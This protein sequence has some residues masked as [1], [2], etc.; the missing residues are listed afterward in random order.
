MIVGQTFHFDASHKLPTHQG[1]CSNLH[2]HTYRLEVEVEGEVGDDGMVMDFSELKKTVKEEVI[3]VL[4]H[5]NL[6]DVVP[7]PTAENLIKWIEDELKHKMHL[8][9]IKI[10]EGD[11]KWAKK[12][13]A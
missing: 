9:S 4:D 6:N 5:A 11:R 3:C 1:P 12:R 8:H 13:F 7:N 2:G 10:Y